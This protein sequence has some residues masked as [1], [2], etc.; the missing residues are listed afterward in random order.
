MTVLKEFTFGVFTYNQ[1]QFIFENLESIKYQI[2]KY[3]GNTSF[4]LVMSDDC[5]RDNTV[6]Y[7]KEW[8]KKNVE[9]F[10][11]IEINSAESNQKIVNNYVA[12]LRRIRTRDF[13]ILAGDDLYYKNNFLSLNSDADVCITAV[14]GFDGDR[15]VPLNNNYNFKRM[16]ISKDLRKY[17]SERLEYSNCVDAPGV[18]YKR[19]LVD[20][21][22]FNELKEYSWIEDVPMWNHFF[23]VKES[24]VKICSDVYILYR[25]SV[26]IS[27][28]INHPMNKGYLEDLKR[29]QEKIHINYRFPYSLYHRI[30]KSLF[31]RVTNLYLDSHSKE[32]INYNKNIAEVS[33]EGNEYL[34]LIKEKAAKYDYM[35]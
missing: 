30:N 32:I 22:L 19:S 16:L 12:L 8:L 31:K 18:F 10:D 35:K 6:V 7:A 25:Q 23:N 9:L 11:R 17:I 28:N 21:F 2:D 4:S 27:N 15:I 24:T 26:G 33:N 5:S 29:I 3:G 20:E 14:A 1:D 34:M 13:K